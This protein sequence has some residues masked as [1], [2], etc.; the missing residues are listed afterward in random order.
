VAETDACRSVS[1]RAVSD[2]RAWA[3]IGGEQVLIAEGAAGPEIEQLAGVEM[4]RRNIAN[5]RLCELRDGGW[6]ETDETL[7]NTSHDP[8]SPTRD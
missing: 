2:W 8:H 3:T 7:R 6:V 4:R 5:C 1:I